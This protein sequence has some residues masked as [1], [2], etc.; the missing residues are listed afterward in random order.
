[1]TKTLGG[2]L[3]ATVFAA[4]FMVASDKE[5]PNIL[6]VLVWRSLFLVAIHASKLQKFQSQCFT[7]HTAFYSLVFC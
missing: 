4:R 7:G 6:D 2:G 1:V 5:M 3:A